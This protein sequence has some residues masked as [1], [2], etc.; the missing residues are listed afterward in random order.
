MI[1]KS[2]NNLEI[3]CNCGAILGEKQGEWYVY[4]NPLKCPECGI[5]NTN[6]LLRAMSELNESFCQKCQ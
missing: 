5:I 4:E 2:K 3:K 6:R 1:V